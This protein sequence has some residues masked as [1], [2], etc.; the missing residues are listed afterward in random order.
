MLHCP[1]GWG[2]GNILF[3]SAQQ[4]SSF[5]SSPCLRL[6]G[7]FLKVIP[8]TRVPWVLSPAQ[9]TFLPWATWLFHFLTSNFHLL[10]C[11][12]GL[13]FS[14][15]LDLKQPGPKAASH[16]VSTLQC[17]CALYQGQGLWNPEHTQS[18]SLNFHSPAKMSLFST[19]RNS[20]S[21]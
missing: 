3:S 6:A 2:W 17:F 10:F 14:A 19:V 8:R 16:P 1:A 15:S 18:P 20:E 12:I 9:G 5:L 21:E 11:S 13:L 4:P 7:S